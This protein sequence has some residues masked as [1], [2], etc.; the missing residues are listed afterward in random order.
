MKVPIDFSTMKSLA[1]YRTFRN[2]EQ[3]LVVSK[4]K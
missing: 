2:L 1:L 3:N 4:Q